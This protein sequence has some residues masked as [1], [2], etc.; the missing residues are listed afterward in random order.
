MSTSRNNIREVV[1]MKHQNVVLTQFDTVLPLLSDEEIEARVF[2]ELEAQQQRRSIDQSSVVILQFP[3]DR[4][5]FQRLSAWW[6]SRGR[7][8]A[9]RSSGETEE[10]VTE[11][12]WQG[13]WAIAKYL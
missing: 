10:V 2:K 3:D 5:V 9:A 4:S 13:H 6:S 1:P 7:G 12:Q 8:E 11:P